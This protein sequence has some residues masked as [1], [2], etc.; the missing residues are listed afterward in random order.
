ASRRSRYRGGATVKVAPLLC[1]LLAACAAP[2]DLIADYQA[3]LGTACIGP[4]GTPDDTVALYE[5]ENDPSGFVIHDTTG[6]QDGVV[7]NGTSQFGAGP[8]GC[9]RSFESRPDPRYINLPALPG[10]A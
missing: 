7:L 8:S 5:F 6:H 3:T 10:C 2:D 1:V 4:T 9:R